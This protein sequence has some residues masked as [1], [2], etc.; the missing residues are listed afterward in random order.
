MQ[1]SNNLTFSAYQ[2]QAEM[3]AVYPGVGERS[4]PEFMY[5]GLGLS[6]EA[7]E[8]ANKIKKLKRDGDTPELRNAIMKEVADVLWYAAQ[9]CT[10]FEYNMGEVAQSNLDNLA[11]R[12]KRGTLHGSGDNR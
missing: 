5:C 11:G 4:L 6:G 3:T 8:A 1:P 12:K 9:L 2:K 7:G 10:V